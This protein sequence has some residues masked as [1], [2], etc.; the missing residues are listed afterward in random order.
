M[1]RV[2]ITWRRLSEIVRFRRSQEIEVLKRENAALRAEKFLAGSCS[3]SPKANVAAEVKS[4]ERRASKKVEA[5]TSVLNGQPLTAREIRRLVTE[6]FP[7]L[8]FDSNY[9][10][11]FLKDSTHRGRVNRI[12][13]RGSFAYTLRKKA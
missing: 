3:E 1:T 13:E 11:V 2:R 4:T 12:G 9:V 5:V 10:N 6:R 7:E 8:K